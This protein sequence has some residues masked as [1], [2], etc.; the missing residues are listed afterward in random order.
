MYKKIFSLLMLA[1]ITAI[2]GYFFNQPNTPLSTK[3]ETQ[4]KKKILTTPQYILTD[5][6]PALTSPAETAVNNTSSRKKIAVAAD[7]D[8]VIG[9]KVLTFENAADMQEF[10][11]QAAQYGFYIRDRIPSLNSLRVY[12][13]DKKSLARLLS[14]HPEID[15]ISDNPAVLTPAP[16]LQSSGKGL[17]QSPRN[18]LGV[19]DNSNWGDGITVAVIDSGIT[20]HNALQGNIQH[21]DLVNDDSEILSSHGTSVASLIAG[22]ADYVQGVSPAVNLLDIRALNNDGVGDSFTV[23][24]AIIA[25]ADAGANIIN[26]SLGSFS[27]SPVLEAAVAY[28][29]QKNII[30]VAAVGNDGQGQVSYPAKYPGVIGVGAVDANANYLSFSN[31][32]EEVDIM[33]PGLQLYASGLDDSVIS[34]SGTSAA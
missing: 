2:S 8:E 12:F 19:K 22:D 21:I 15:L 11:K 13:P 9:D 25:A 18:F 6:S 1:L 32:G 29:L 5:I 20:D 23:A 28:A 7:K 31:R 30:L 16:L 10:I 33:A 34:F 24:K 4:R 26:L 14:D 27:D 17:N 3:K